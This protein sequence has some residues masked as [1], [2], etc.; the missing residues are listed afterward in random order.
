MSGAAFLPGHASEAVPGGLVGYRRDLIPA[1]LHRI[2][3]DEQGAYFEINL[4]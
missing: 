2:V 3:H 1:G 4:T